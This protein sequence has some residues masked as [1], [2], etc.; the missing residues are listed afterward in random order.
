MTPPF[1]SRT[2]ELSP[3]TA[4]YWSVSTQ[5]KFWERQY[6]PKTE[7]KP[8]NAKI[9]TGKKLYTKL[10]MQNAGE[11]QYSAEAIIP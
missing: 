11:A 4:E 8:I 5:S 2:I 10:T 6:K 7:Q 1:L 3:V 9:F